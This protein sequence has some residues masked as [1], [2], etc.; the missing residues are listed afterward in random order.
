MSKNIF[1][2]LTV[3]I[4]AYSRPLDID[5]LLYSISQM[6][7]LP[8]EIVIC[9]DM[10]PERLAIEAVAKK[11]LE[12]FSEMGVSLIYHENAVNKGYDGNVRTL[13]HV[14]TRKW[15]MLMGDDDLIL[16]NS[17]SLIREA[18][19]KFP[20]VK[21]FSRSFLRFT[22]DINSPIGFSS[23]SEVDLIFSS[24]NKGASSIFR[25]AAFVGGLVI[26]REWALKI[27][28]ADY[29]GTLYYQIYLSGMAFYGEGIGYIST[30]LVGG[31]T[32]NPP[33]FGASASET[34]VHVPG[35][36]RPKGRAAMWRGVL[37]IAGDLQLLK[38]LPVTGEIRRELD[39]HQSFHIFEMTSLQSRRASFE[40]VH[41]LRLLGLMRHPLPWLYFVIN[42]VFGR[43]AIGI[44]KLARYIMQG[45]WKKS[46]ALKVN[47]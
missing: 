5:Q 7:L 45:G 40:L 6:V 35:A 28:R 36:Y 27:E 46:G 37:R 29:D 23:Q 38:G 9:E 22:N 44:Y 2:D 18:T 8:G 4:P 14:A 47:G 17:A 19:C 11:W 31:R 25:L 10:S 32:G 24:E 42:L 12:K 21:F 13:F 1:G 26:D 16:E 15:V 3:A 33:L 39:V 41:E 30:A 34:E 20:N 43:F